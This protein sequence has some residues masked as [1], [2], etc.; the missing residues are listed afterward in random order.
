MD[1]ESRRKA[2]VVVGREVMTAMQRIVEGKA[3][4][5]QFT[6]T[7][8]IAYDLVKMGQGR[9]LQNIIKCSVRLLVRTM[10]SKYW[11]L[12]CT[13]M[14]DMTMYH[15][16]VWCSSQGEPAILDILE[17]ESEAVRC[18]ASAVLAPVLAKRWLTIYYE[19]GGRFVKRSHAEL[20][21]CWHAPS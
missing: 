6:H 19:P 5:V 8:K 9:M 10:P 4:D 16:R 3:Y 7:Y 13:M 15:Q 1:A 14:R 11:R 17:H 18:W 2:G 20:E 21:K 12:A